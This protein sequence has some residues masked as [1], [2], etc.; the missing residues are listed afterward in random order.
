MREK[1][2]ASERNVGMYVCMREK[3]RERAR[4]AE[5][6]RD[7][8]W[9]LYVAWATQSLTDVSTKRR[10]NVF[11]QLA[12]KLNT[13]RHTHSFACIINTWLLTYIL[14]YIHAYI[15]ARLKSL[16]VQGAEG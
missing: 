9:D 16:R 11:C 7:C 5:R 13:Y 15:H 12:Y 8:V 1:E 14:A 3:E 2:R 10:V 4:E 6:E